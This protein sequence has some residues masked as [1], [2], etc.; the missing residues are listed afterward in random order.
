MQKP[1]LGAPWTGLLHSYLQLHCL[2]CLNLHGGESI[3]VS[4]ILNSL[5]CCDVQQQCRLVPF[6]F[7]GWQRHLIAALQRSCCALHLLLCYPAGLH[8]A[9][10]QLLEEPVLERFHHADRGVQS[11]GVGYRGSSE[12]ALRAH[13][14]MHITPT[15]YRYAGNLCHLQPSSEVR[16]LLAHLGVRIKVYT[17]KCHV[18]IS[19]QGVYQVAFMADA[20]E[21]QVIPAKSLH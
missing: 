13:P 20:A 3:L 12:L 14:P 21:R 1:Y 7:A 10:F 11:C 19:H 5:R 4:C 18:R 16:V 8:V 15:A 9:L 2:S 6:M 17:I